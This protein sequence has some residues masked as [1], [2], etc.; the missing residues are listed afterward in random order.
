MLISNTFKNQGNQAFDCNVCNKYIPDNKY[1]I[2]YFI[3]CT[4]NQCILADILIFHN[5]CE[6]KEQLWKNVKSVF[7]GNKKFKYVTDLNNPE[8]LINIL[9]LF[10][11]NRITL[12]ART[13]IDNLITRNIFNNNNKINLDYINNSD[14]PCKENVRRD[15][16]KLKSG[17]SKYYIYS[18][19]SNNTYGF[20]KLALPKEQKSSY[21]F[22]Q[23]NE[24]IFDSVI[25]PEII[26]NSI[27]SN[28]HYLTELYSYLFEISYIK[29]HP[30]NS[31][32]LLT[33][34]EKLITSTN[35]SQN[36][37]IGNII[38]NINYSINNNI[39]SQNNI[40]TKDIED[41]KKI[42]IQEDNN[43]KT[44]KIKI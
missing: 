21:S 15:I 40:D 24:H 16:K 7:E 17:I 9:K 5:T 18:P 44:K 22:N 12:N 34:I 29:R 4:T 35:V 14:F 3:E 26:A 28:K 41:I 8:K 2:I 6:C 43:V 11:D 27:I 37:N 13:K 23:D 1:G 10:Y 30:I 19:L 25:I 36:I 31:I 33:E 42:V 20:I 32:K 38:S 39:I